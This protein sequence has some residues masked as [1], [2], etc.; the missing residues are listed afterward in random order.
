M[1]SNRLKLVEISSELRTSLHNHAFPTLTITE[2]PTGR[3]PR[4]FTRE[5]NFPQCVVQIGGGFTPPRSI[6]GGL[7]A[8]YG[9]SVYYVFK[10]GNNDDINIKKMIYGRELFDW[11]A[12]NHYGTYYKLFMNDEGQDDVELD[13]QPEEERIYIAESGTPNQVGI[14]MIALRFPVE[15]RGVF[16]V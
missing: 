7:G 11:L 8:I 14:A 16:T 4:R 5:E 15:Q 6:G 9:V 12:D 1:P 10:Y 3:D 2:I 13:L